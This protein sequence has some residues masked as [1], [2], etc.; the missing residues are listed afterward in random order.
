[1]GKKTVA[2]II[3]A[4]VLLIVTVYIY[5]R[6]FHITSVIFKTITPSV[7]DITMKRDILCLFMAYPEYIADI[8]RDTDGKVFIVMKSGKHII[9]DDMITKSFDGKLANPDLQDM[10]DQIY[11]ISHTNRLMPDNIDPGR[12]RVYALLKEVYGSTRKQVETNLIN[13]HIDNIYCI[14]SSKN[15]A[16]DALKAA[17][18]E[19]AYLMRNNPSIRQFV[20][21]L[22]GTFNYR[23]IAGTNRLSAHSFGNAIDLASNGRDYWQWCS[24]IDGE[25]RL[26]VYPKQIVAAFEKNGFIW[27]GKWAHFD[28]MHFEY[29]PEIILKARYFSCEPAPEKPWHQG[30]PADSE[31]ALCFI[32]MINERID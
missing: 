32:K 13:V 7:Y 4:I 15:G 26:E 27:G 10:M 22:G 12:F 28:I 1:M 18:S 14:F 9:Y 17:L 24:K 2:N 23:L 5:M 20:L 31:P 8:V 16:S 6:L 19:I 3:V 21:P 25:K 11:P 29:R 30:A